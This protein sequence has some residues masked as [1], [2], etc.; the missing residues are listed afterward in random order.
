MFFLFLKPASK[1]FKKI[2]KIRE[3]EKERIIPASGKPING[4]EFSQKYGTKM[5]KVL[6]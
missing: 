2:E 4:D 3:W 6:Q 1:K 5:R